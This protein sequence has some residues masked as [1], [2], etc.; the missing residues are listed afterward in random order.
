MLA[1][2]AEPRDRTQPGPAGAVLR[3]SVSGE[4]VVQ[5][6]GER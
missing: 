2:D 5:E 6:A 1:K 3:Y 4:A